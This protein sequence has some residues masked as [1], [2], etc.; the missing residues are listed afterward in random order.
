MNCGIVEVMIEMVCA[1]KLQLLRC[2][3]MT[4]KRLVERFDRFV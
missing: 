2:V 1:V 3:M 4:T